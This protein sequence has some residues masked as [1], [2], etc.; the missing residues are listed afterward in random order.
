MDRGDA[1]KKA[2]KPERAGR[3]GGGTAESTGAGAR[4][5]TGASGEK[6]GNGAPAL[7]EEVL[8]RENLTAAY[9]RVVRNG[10]AGGVD[11][12]SVDDLKEQLHTDWPHIREQLLNGTYKPSPVRRVEIPKP[13]GG[14]RTLGIPTV[15]DRMIQ[16]ALSQALTPIFD[17]TFSEDSYGFRPGRS[18]HHAVQ[19]A[20]EHI[21]AGHRWVVD[22]DLEAFFD[23]VNHDVLIAR[24]KRKVKDKRVL[25]LI[26]RYLRAGMME[27]GLT[28]PRTEGTPQ[29]GPLSPL[30]SNILLDDLDKEL[31]QRGHR[32][33]RYADDFQVYMKSEAAGERV[34]ASLESFLKK[35]LRLKVN[36][37]KSAVGRP[38]K[39]KFLGYR[40]T[41]EKKPKLKPDPKSV[42]RLKTK[43]KELFRRGRGWSLART[44]RELNPVLR[45]W[46]Y[47]YRLSDVE[48][49]FEALDQWVRR[50]LRLILWRQWKRPRTRAKELRKRGLDQDRAWRSAYNGRGPWWNAGSRHMNQAVPT[51]AL[52]QMGLV[53]LLQQHRRLKCCS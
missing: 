36:S 38:W 29:G 20:K 34:K 43:L 8:R 48:G 16:Q 39:R 51:R 12:R 46:G 17:P 15:M 9:E 3:I 1:G 4:Q 7:M 19:R 37:R 32:F 18:T 11:G 14:V 50:R 33:V 52:H 44:I 5:A 6:A 27:G 49:V 23:T 53:S 30:L 31:E 22:L 40:T 21:E 26:G 42:E 41:T 13:G 2:E 47:Y 24:V 10:G 45:G 28:S 25:R 35:R